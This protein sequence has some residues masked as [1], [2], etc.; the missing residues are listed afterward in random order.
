MPPRS[1]QVAADARTK[2]LS[3][4]E[5]EACV[6]V[7]NAARHLARLPRRAYV[8][9]YLWNRRLRAWSRFYDDILAVRMRLREREERGE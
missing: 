1:L 6:G 8:R 4:L 7:A 3:E 2:A 9:R 5:T